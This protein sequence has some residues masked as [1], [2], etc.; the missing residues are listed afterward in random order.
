[1]KK[2]LALLFLS[3]TPQIAF[4]A[5]NCPTGQF[6]DI[7]TNSCLSTYEQFINAAWNTGT[8][9]I[10]PLSV[11]VIT[12]AGVV[13][14]TSE[15]DPKKIKLARKLIIGVLS[16]IGLIILSRVILVSILGLDPGTAW[17]LK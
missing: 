6:Y 1:M 7:F 5:P 12:A 11:V 2:I 9:I 16:G 3:A 10:I 4:A 13:W 17:N 15:G 14:T 8:A